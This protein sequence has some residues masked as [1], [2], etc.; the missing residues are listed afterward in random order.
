VLGGIG[1]TWEHDAHLYLKRAM[2]VRQLLGG[3][4]RWRASVARQALAGRR[5]DL[6]LEF[7]AEAEGIRAEVRAFGEELQAL[8][9]GDWNTRL[10]DDGYLAP[11]WPQP[12]SRHAGPV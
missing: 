2:A 4:A 5:R 12:W 10:A 1:F 11:H 9:R 6:H 3:T 8:D 7:P